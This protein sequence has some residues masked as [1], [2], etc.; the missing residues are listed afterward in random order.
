M[1]PQVKMHSFQINTGPLAVITHHGEDKRRV[2][3]SQPISLMAEVGS[4]C[5]SFSLDEKNF[6]IEYALFVCCRITDIW[7]LLAFRNYLN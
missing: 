7:D 2:V 6:F 5:I 1:G 4:V 3:S